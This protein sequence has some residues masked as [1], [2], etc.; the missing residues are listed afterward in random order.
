MGS[1]PIIRSINH[2]NPVRVFLLFVLTKWIKKVFNFENCTLVMKKE[3]ENKRSIV[4]VNASTEKKE[5]TG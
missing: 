3:T 2:Y 1:I 5:K 4:K